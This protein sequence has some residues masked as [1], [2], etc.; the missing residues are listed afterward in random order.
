M[1]TF[2]S[3][4]TL[5]IL[6]HL[7][8]YHSGTRDTMMASEVKIGSS[9]DVDIHFPA[10]KVPQVASLHAHLWQADNGYRIKAV[11]GVIRVNDEQV[12]EAQLQTNDLIQLGDHGPL[13]RFRLYEEVER[14]YKT[15][16]E[17]VNDCVDCAKKESESAVG[18]TVA[19]FRGLPGQMSHLYPATRITVTGMLV[20]FLGLTLFL[21]WQTAQLRM[22]L[23]EQATQLDD[24]SMIWGDAETMEEFWKSRNE[25]S[26]TVESVIAIRDSLVAQLTEAQERINALEARSDAG[27]RIIASATE[28]V[29]FLQ[30]AYG[31]EDSRGKSAPHTSR[32]VWK[33][34][35]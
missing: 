20:G 11:D 18:R 10:A 16:R 30:G 8:G 2:S 34:V 1:T 22:S 5:V 9:A 29:M 12:T 28:A 31:F 25:E 7:S 3:N 19:F 6:D 23:N 15:V 21:A 24:I 32:C 26:P 14:P 17:A 13:L 33:S 27:Q 35:T 4:H